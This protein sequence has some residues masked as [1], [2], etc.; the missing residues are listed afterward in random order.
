MND[1]QIRTVLTSLFG[2]QQY[3]GADG[4]IRVYGK[5]PATHQSGWYLFGN[6]A[7]TATHRVLTQLAHAT[8]AA[9]VIQAQ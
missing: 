2:T 5:M 4:G 6:V 3:I 7:D 1:T 8:P 9:P